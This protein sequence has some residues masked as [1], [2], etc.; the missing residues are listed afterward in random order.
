MN[1]V[2]LLNPDTYF[3]FILNKRKIIFHLMYI[4]V[5]FV[6]KVY[7]LPTKGH[8]LQ[9]WKIAIKMSGHHSVR[10]NQVRYKYGS[11]KYFWFA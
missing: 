10:F 1:G 6:E 4:K 5:R 3:L 11:K 9:Y 8:F 2:E 7:I